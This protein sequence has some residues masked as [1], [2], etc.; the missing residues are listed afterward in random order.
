LTENFEK[1]LSPFLEFT[2]ISN[3]SAFVESIEDFY[4]DG[5]ITL[6]FNNNI[7]EVRLRMN[8]AGEATSNEIILLVI[9]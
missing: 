7:T 3:V 1:Y 6:N 4:F 5:N 2:Q 9:E 8:E